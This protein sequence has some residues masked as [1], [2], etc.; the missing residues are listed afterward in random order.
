MDER[1]RGTGDR[2][3]QSDYD[4]PFNKRS[5]FGD[6]RG[7]GAGRFSE[8]YRNS[9]GG[10]RYEERRRGGGTD[11]VLDEDLLT[12]PSYESWRAKSSAN[13]D[14]AQYCEHVKDWVKN[15]ND[16]FAKRHWKE[17]WFLEKY[18]PERMDERIKERKQSAIKRASELDTMTFVPLVQSSDEKDKL[19]T[20]IEPNLDETMCAYIPH[21]GPMVPRA[22][23]E[24]A[25]IAEGA[26]T[27]LLSEVN[28]A[29]KR[30]DL[31]RRGTVI[32]KDAQS[33]KDCI[34]KGFITCWITTDPDG[35]TFESQSVK[36]DRRTELTINIINYKTLP[37]RLLPIEANIPQRMEKD[38]KQAIACA[39]LL[40]TV[41]GIESGGIKAALAAKPQSVTS[42]DA[43]VQ[44]LRH[45]HL[46]CYYSGSLCKD[47]GEFIHKSAT[48]FLRMPLNSPSITNSSISITPETASKDETNEVAESEE[49]DIKSVIIPPS[50]KTAGGA[51]SDQTEQLDGRKFFEI[52]DLAAEKI[53]TQFPQQYTLE[54]ERTD[55]G[56]KR[57]TVIAAETLE[58]FVTENIVMKNTHVYC[59]VHEKLFQN[60]VFF[61]KHLLNFHGAAIRSSQRKGLFDLFMEM[62]NYDDDKPLPRLPK[63]VDDIL[64]GDFTPPP[65][66]ERF[67]RE[68]RPSLST[69]S[70]GYSPNPR[71]GGDYGAEAT[72][73]SEPAPVR[74]YRDPDA[75]KQ[76][77]VAEKPQK[78]Q[79]RT[80]VSYGAPL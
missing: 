62:Y 2:R 53:K 1:D 17:D 67:Q 75:P 44:Y 42:L 39:E 69:G 16:V 40:D 23:L 59:Q 14:P 50:E 8:E 11:F 60:E 57:K 7:G 6:D 78:L 61:R 71:V 4:R 15:R 45:V 10:S 26:I 34:T 58:S 70:G 41:F 49:V 76:N 73:R 64:R 25:L 68:P 46:Y 27:L 56:L 54:V 77:V 30:R 31:G 24:K 32:F 9:A 35:V 22:A 19:I 5:R 28:R 33:A 36:D 38:E 12:C 47:Y 3:R 51:R 74:K 79:Y 48:P 80:R 20:G 18:D 63:F 55:D 66:R 43:A 72:R 13:V 21:I 29:K 65:E 37:N 52:V